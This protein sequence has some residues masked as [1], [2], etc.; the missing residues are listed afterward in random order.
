M[1]LDESVFVEQILVMILD[2]VS[3]T[4]ESI[5]KQ[6]RTKEAAYERLLKAGIIDKSG[7]LTKIY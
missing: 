2:R 6:P 1:C 3:K 5:E 4:M 7:Q